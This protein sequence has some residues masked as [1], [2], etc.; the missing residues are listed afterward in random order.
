MAGE[1]GL[2]YASLC[3]VERLANGVGEDPLSA[4]Q[5][6]AGRAA[7]RGVLETVLGA[8]VPTLGAQSS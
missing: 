5:L 4:A 3:V 7:S 6:A 2:A 1:L 8:I